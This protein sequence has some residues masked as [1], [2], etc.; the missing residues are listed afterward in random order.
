MS[1]HD[2]SRTQLDAGS[3]LPRFNMPFEFGLFIG[4]REYGGAKHANKK[5]LVFAE[6]KFDYQSYISDIAGQ[7]ISMHDNDPK[8][9]MAKVRH[10]LRGYQSSIPGAPIIVKSYAKFSDELPALAK[11]PQFRYDHEDL[12]FQ[13]YVALV[14]AFLV[15]SGWQ[16]SRFD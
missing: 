10:F 5:C 8:K 3:G 13:D 16:I 15:I 14:K 9:A 2:L 6:K 1:I 4:A 7:D 11:L 12:H